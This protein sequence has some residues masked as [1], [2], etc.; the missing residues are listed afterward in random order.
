MSKMIKIIHGK[1]TIVSK[2]YLDKVRDS[3]KDKKIIE[4]DVEDN[5]G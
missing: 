5:G 4:I 3:F 2:M 1:N